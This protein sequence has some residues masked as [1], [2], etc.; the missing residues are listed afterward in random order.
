MNVLIISHT[1]CAAINRVKWKVL[2]KLYP[3]VN[4]TVIMPKIWPDVLF[5][6]RCDNVAKENLPNCKFVALNTFKAG[7]EVLYGY[8]PQDLIKIFY[9]FKPDIVHVEQ[10]D[11][12]FSYFQAIVL[13]KIFC[14]KAKYSF[15]TWIN[16]RVKRS[17]KYRLLWGWI[18]R[19]NLKYTTGAFLGN[20]AAKDILLSK[21]FFKPAKVLPLIGVDLNFFTPTRRNDCKK[22][23]FIGRFVKEKGIYLLVDAFSKLTN[24]YE[25][26][27]L[28]FVGGGLE[29]NNLKNY[30]EQLGCK[31]RIFFIISAS[32]EQIRDILQK[33]DILVL[34]S[35]DMEDWKEQFGHVL[36]EAMATKIPVIGS[37]AGEI[38][39]VIGEAG[40]VFKQRDS[41]DLEVCL[42]K[43]IQDPELRIKLTA[44]AYERVKNKYSHEAIARETYNFWE[45]LG[46]GFSKI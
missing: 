7:N 42:R 34:P 2:S 11:N 33:V 39:N 45:K 18:E 32:H 3:N 13:G 19:L 8:Y 6:H 38:P 9:N 15:F 20:Q 17:L 37:D 35:F 25:K 27:E 14:S 24:E 46:V 1:A 40:L 22:I 5:T 21:N 26:L 16:W 43:L 36:I 44:L 10:G 4:L 31:D 23:I 29:L 30:V 12:A 41:K 28:I